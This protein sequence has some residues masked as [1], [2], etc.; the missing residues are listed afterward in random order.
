MQ[1]IRDGRAALTSGT[2]SRKQQW[3]LIGAVMGF[4]LVRDLILCVGLPAIVWLSANPK[5]H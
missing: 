4:Y 1:R 2:L 3:R 5:P